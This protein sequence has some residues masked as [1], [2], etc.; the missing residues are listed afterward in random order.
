M[1]PTGQVSRKRASSDQL[2]EQAKRKVRPAKAKS[3]AKSRASGSKGSATK[4]P[5]TKSRPEGSESSSRRPSSPE[6]PPPIGEITV[7][8]D[9][10]N[11]EFEQQESTEAD[12]EHM[13]LDDEEDTDDNRHKKNRTK[14]PKNLTKDARTMALAAS[15]SSIITLVRWL[16]QV[17]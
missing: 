8:D 10:D 12:E 5:T 17:S 14:G 9:S 13:Y 16:P 1:A 2:R 15:R 11:S 7:S 6:L 3:I 4:G